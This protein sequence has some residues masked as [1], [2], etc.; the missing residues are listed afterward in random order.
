MFWVQVAQEREPYRPIEPKT[1][2]RAR[3][4]RATP[5]S[6]KNATTTYPPRSSLDLQETEPK[7]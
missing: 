7:P 1:G 6:Q 2:N 5:C 3:Q 4:R